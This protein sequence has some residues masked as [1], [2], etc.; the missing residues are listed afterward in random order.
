[1]RSADR[2]HNVVKH[3]QIWEEQNS[4]LTNPLLDKAKISQQLSRVEQAK[5][6][7]EKRVQEL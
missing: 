7:L 4:G 2:F 1:M 3:N 6:E 5:V